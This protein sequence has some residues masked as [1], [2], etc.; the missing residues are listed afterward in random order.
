MCS[1]DYHGHRTGLGVPTSHK[2]LILWQCLSLQCQDVLNE[3]NGE[4]DSVLNRRLKCKSTTCSKGPD[5]LSF[6]LDLRISE[7]PEATK[8]IAMWQWKGGCLSNPLWKKWRVCSCSDWTRQPLRQ[9]FIGVVDLGI[10]V[11]E[12]PDDHWQLRRV[13]DPLTWPSAMHNAH[14]KLTTIQ[15][16]GETKWQ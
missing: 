11:M 2:C 15:D 5:Q 8:Y 4:P 3:S 13:S 9:Y 7:A 6:S 14:D 1:T 10:Q 12:K 16:F